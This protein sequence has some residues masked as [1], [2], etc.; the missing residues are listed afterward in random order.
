MTY[1]IVQSFKN[2]GGSIF[3][4][5]PSILQ[6]AALASPNEAKRTFIFLLLNGFTL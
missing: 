5:L 4:F 3:K 6:T 1:K 2:C